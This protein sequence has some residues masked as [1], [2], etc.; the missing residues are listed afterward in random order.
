[1]LFLIDKDKSFGLKLIQFP[2]TMSKVYVL[3]Y[4]TQQIG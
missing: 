4:I 1:M 2:E 3:K